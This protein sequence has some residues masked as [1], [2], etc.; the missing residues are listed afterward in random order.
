MEH[1]DAGIGEDEVANPQYDYDYTVE[2][3]GEAYSEWPNLAGRRENYTTV[4]PIL[5]NPHPYKD[6]DNGILSI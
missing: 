3:E 1:N 4:M 6:K 2:G 5:K